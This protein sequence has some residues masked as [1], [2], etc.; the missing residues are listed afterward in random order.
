[1]PLVGAIYTAWAGSGIGS[2]LIRG[3]FAGICLIPPTLMMGATLPAISRWVE[4]D[5]EGVSW[6]GFFYGGNIAG[7]VVGSLLAG[8][9]LLRVHDVSV[10]TFAAVAINVVV[11]ALGLMIAKASPYTSSRGVG[12]DR[13]AGA[14]GRVD[15]VRD[16]CALGHDGA[17]RP[18]SS[19]RG[20]CRCCSA[21]RCT[22][23]R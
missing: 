9:Y 4:T 21:R 20:S 7:A 5:T 6:L 16:D 8:F 15:G 14:S 22:R 3:L 17:R 19:G 18:R 12:T 13:V 23:S 2:I 10:A 11:A 1:M